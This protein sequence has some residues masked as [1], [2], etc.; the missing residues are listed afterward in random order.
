MSNNQKSNNS[1]S[2]P[3]FSVISGNHFHGFS[4]VFKSSSVEEIITECMR[5]EEELGNLPNS[6]VEMSLDNVKTVFICNE[7]GKFDEIELN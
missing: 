2:A 4:S 3:V 1:S 5:A 7:Q 6:F